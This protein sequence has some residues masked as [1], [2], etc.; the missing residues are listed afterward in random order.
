M[1]LKA[2]VPGIVVYADPAHPWEHENV[3][4]G[5]PVWQNMCVCTIP[6]T[7]E[8]TVTVQVH[9]ADVNTVKTGMPVNVTLDTYKGLALQGA[10]TRVASVAGQGDWLEHVKKFEVDIAL[11]GSSLNLRPGITARAEIAVGELR[12]VVHVPLQ[13]IFVEEG[14]HLCYVRRG[15]RN[16][17]TVVEV[18]GSNDHYVEVKKGL[19]EGD[20]VLLYK[21]TNGEA[22]S[23]RAAASPPPALRVPVA[24]KP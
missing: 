21:P 23:P 7:S 19:A 2:P 6:D 16:V 1:T 8:M 3:K 9:E 4:L 11:V 20:L 13:A 12:N 14:K 15:G 5:N 18:G 10:V 17:A 22:T 24:G